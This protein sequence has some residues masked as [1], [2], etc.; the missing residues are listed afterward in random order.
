VPFDA[1]EYRLMDRKVV[2]ALRALPERSRF[3]KGLFPWVGFKTVGVPFS[4]DDR[5]AGRSKFSAR[6]LSALALTGIT[7]FSELP[8]R[9]WGLLGA[10]VSVLALFYAGWIVIETLIFGVDV[11]GWATLAAA[12]MF[13]GGVQL[14]S[15]GILGEYVG[16]IY[17]EVKQRPLYLVARKYGF[18][19][20]PDAIRSPTT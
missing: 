20:T 19:K 14:L 17:N 4:V 5:V 15:I 13:F 7:S 12:L 8:L 2:E 16:R 3:S 9:I 1:S 6:R 18:P 11:P 10:L